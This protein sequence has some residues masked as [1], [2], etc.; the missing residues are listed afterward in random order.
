MA[1]SSSQKDLLRKPVARALAGQS[2][3]YDLRA[4]TAS[5]NDARAGLTSQLLVSFP[6]DEY[7]CNDEIGR[8]K[9]EIYVL[10]F[11]GEEFS[12]E[13]REEHEGIAVI[14]IQLASKA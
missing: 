14:A 2:F 12:L 11:P 3:N 8:L 5:V 7:R 6:E 10:Q 4:V 1:D 9:K 13:V